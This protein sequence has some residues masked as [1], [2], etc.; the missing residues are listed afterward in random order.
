MTKEELKAEVLNI[1][2][3]FEEEDLKESAGLLYNFEEELLN[4]FLAL[5]GEVKKN[6]KLL[7]KSEFDID[8]FIKFNENF[9]NAIDSLNSFQIEDSGFNE[10]KVG[11]NSTLELWKNIVNEIELKELAIIGENFNSQVQ[12]AIEVVNEDNFKDREIIEVIKQGY[13]YKDNII[14]YAQVKINKKDN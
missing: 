1:I 7:V 6:T 13:T 2:D 3:S 5:K 9:L 12:E 14:N 4:E 11:L 8:K 10:L